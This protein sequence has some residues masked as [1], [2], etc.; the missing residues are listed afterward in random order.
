MTV[1]PQVQQFLAEMAAA[2]VP[3]MHEQ[4]PAEARQQMEAA[5]AALAKPSVDSIEDQLV[6]GADGEIPIRI[7]K[8]EG[9]PGFYDRGRGVSEHGQAWPSSLSALIRLRRGLL[10]F[11]NLKD[12]VVTDI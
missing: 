6:A 2:T 9:N 5:S 3:A 8:P 7:Y 12:Q 10:D 1:D 4:T 11:D